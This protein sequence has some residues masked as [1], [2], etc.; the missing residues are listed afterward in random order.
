[1]NNDDTCYYEAKQ[2]QKHEDFETLESKFSLGFFY[3]VV[4]AILKQN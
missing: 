4:G 1:M 2:G 3:S